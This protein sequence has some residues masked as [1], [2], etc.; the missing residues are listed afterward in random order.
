MDRKIATAVVGTLSLLVLASP[1]PALADDVCLPLTAACTTDTITVDPDEGADD[2]IGTIVDVV[3]GAEDTTDPTVD[4]VVD[5]VLDVVD[6]VL[7]GG[8]IVD[9]PGGDGPRGHRSGPGTK[10][11]GDERQRQDPRTTAPRPGALAREAFRPP[12]PIIGSA[13]SGVRPP[14]GPHGSPGRLDGIVE[15]AVRGL[16]L[17]AVLFGVT[18]GFVVVQGR[19]D[20]N[21]PK[22]IGAPVRTEIVTFA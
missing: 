18:V 7:N 22:L 14:V 12:G 2:P 17:L 13:A 1:A 21:D 11:Q 9:P 16:L 8:D 10:V 20:R 3:D 6:D 4:P 15:G 5:P 19:L